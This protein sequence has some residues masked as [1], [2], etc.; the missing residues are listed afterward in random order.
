MTIANYE[1]RT[2]VPATMKPVVTPSNSLDTYIQSR[3]KYI[4]NKKNRPVPLKGMMLP[5][6]GF[7]GPSIY[8]RALNA[9]RSKEPEEEAYTHCS[10]T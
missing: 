10:M 5:G 6:T 9:L 4:L 1:P 2:A 7:P 8:I 3:K